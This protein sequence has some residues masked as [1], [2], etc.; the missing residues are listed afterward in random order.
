MTPRM[1]DESPAHRRPVSARKQKSN[2]SKASAVKAIASN[3]T[4]VGFAI[5]LLLALIGTVQFVL[6]LPTPQEIVVKRFFKA[7]ANGDYP[8]ASGC[9][10]GG[11]FEVVAQNSLIRGVPGG[12]ILLGSAIAD[13]GTIQ[14]QL[15]QAQFFVSQFRFDTLKGQRDK[16][17]D[18]K[19]VQFNIAFDVYPGGRR[20]MSPSPANTMG[21]V[22][23]G[24]AIVIRSGPGWVI[25][26][27]DFRAIPQRGTKITD[28]LQL[29]NGAPGPIEGP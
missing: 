11:R 26:A 15:P 25:H 10:E 20:P 8:T 13:E 27:L 28:L 1:R 16:N 22:I 6:S 19:T 21:F 7:I 29:I 5:F 9:L 12:S 3:P 23:E 17:P 2:S 4:V 18:R 14:A 24:H